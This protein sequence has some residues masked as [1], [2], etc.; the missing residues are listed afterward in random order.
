MLP[1]AHLLAKIGADTAEN[2][3]RFAEI[4]PI[5][6][7]V[8]DPGEACIVGDLYL[9]L[10]R[11]QLYGP[12]RPAALL[13]SSRN[14]VSLSNTRSGIQSVTHIELMG[15]KLTTLDSSKY[16]QFFSDLFNFILT[17]SHLA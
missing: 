15:N 10:N 7:R 4:L 9:V 3:Q 14:C 16:W 2:E 17:L 8:A 6:R 12:A 1:N 5:G 11:Q 13:R